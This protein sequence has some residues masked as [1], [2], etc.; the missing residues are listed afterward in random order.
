MEMYPPYFWPLFLEMQNFADAK[1]KRVSVF[2]FAF[3]PLL[4]WFSEASE[5][6]TFSYCMFKFELKPG[7]NKMPARIQSG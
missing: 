3:S 5:M 2:Y 7:K 1:K 6:K 4:F